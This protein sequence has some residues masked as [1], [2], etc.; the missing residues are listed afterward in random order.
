MPTIVF[1]KAAENYA[2]SFDYDPR[3]I[4]AALHQ[5]GKWAADPALSFTWNDAAIVSQ[6]IRPIRLDAIRAKIKG[7]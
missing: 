4:D 3:S 5:L 1:A 2:V 7:E 6:R